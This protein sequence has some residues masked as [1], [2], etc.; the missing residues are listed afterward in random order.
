KPK[1]FS[2]LM[3]L[4]IKAGSG[5]ILLFL[6]PDLG[7]MLIVAALIYLMACLYGE[8]MATIIKIT[9][10]I[11][12]S[13]VAFIILGGSTKLLEHQSGR[14]TAWIDPFS[15]A[16]D[17]GWGAVQALI[18]ISNGDINGTGY[19]G[20]IQK[21]IFK[22]GAATD[23]I[24]VIICEEW[25]L[26]GAVFVIGSLSLLAYVC[27]LVGNRAKN[28]FGML[29]AYGFGLLILLQLFV[30]IGGVTNLIP[31]TGV[32]LP[33]I[34][35]GINSFVLLSIGLFIVIIID[36]ESVRERRKANEQSERLFL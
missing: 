25:G 3:F 24:F 5:C 22:T 13:I 29:Y 16:K 27:M 12:S 32:T 35:N 15:V 2:E 28:R 33:F 21:T 20:S 18:A 26:I 34:S 36:H 1:T 8:F 7:G 9:L 6:Q 17:E 4:C 19:L 14:F 23:Y 31:M 11:I 30:N 10:G